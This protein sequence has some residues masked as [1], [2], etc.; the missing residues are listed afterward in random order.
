MNRE[1]ALVGVPVYSIV[2]GRLGSIDAQ[3]ES[4]GR[5]NFIRER[6]QIEGIDLISRDRS[7]SSGVNIPDRVE[8]F[9]IEQINSFVSRA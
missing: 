1:A 5:I 2:S 7:D 4:D 6:S 3:M 8:R 9:V